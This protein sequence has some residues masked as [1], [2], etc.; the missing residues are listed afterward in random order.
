[1]KTIRSMIVVVAVTGACAP[2]QEPDAFGNVEAVTV[3]ASAQASGQLLMFEV[4]EGQTLRA[5]DVVG[6]IE[7]TELMLERDQ[8]TA[9]R[10]AT[11]AR[12]AEVD[13]QIE[14]LEAQR[15]VVEAQRAAA[16]AQRSGLAAVREI[17]QRS[18]D[19]T[20]RL[21]DQQAATAQQR[22][23]A[24]REMRTAED[25]L[26]AQD[27]QIRALDRQVDA[28]AAQAAAARAQRTSVQRQVA[29]LTAQVARASERVGKAEVRN[30]LDGTVLVT[31]A[32]AGEVVQ[33]AQP[34]YSIADLRRV[35]VRAY[36]S[37]TQLASVQ[38]GQTARITF[39]RGDVRASLAGAVT[40][41]ASQ[42]EFTPTP[43][44]T[45]EERTDLV[46]ALKIS[47]PNENGLLKIGMPVDV[48]FSEAAP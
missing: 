24:E 23:Q 5:G 39:D 35:D 26:R 37:E 9:L 36:I 28:Q 13:H 16:M 2:A 30:P 21:F 11:S 34:L 41:I 38:L 32:H 42:A 6:A 40:W 3:T 27:E 45:R 17:A 19:R 10:E 7:T 4:T 31:Y 29:S 14:V 33:V 8:L 48:S 25:Q 12:V 47:V 22:D 1:M 44:Q 43:V 20:V 46:Y 15:A 18:Y